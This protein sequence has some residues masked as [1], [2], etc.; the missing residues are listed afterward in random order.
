MTLLLVALLLMVAMVAASGHVWASSRLLLRRMRA[1]EKTAARKPYKD[2]LRGLRMAALN[3]LTLVSLSG[4][5]MVYLVF[6]Y[7]PVDVVLLLGMRL[8]VSANRAMLLVGLGVQAIL[9]VHT[10]AVLVDAIRC[11]YFPPSM[12]PGAV[13]PED[14][15]ERA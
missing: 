15:E 11:A 12:V 10:V 6:G 7:T 2:T 13:A 14:V 8:P 5:T 1:T 4:I 9:L 3:A